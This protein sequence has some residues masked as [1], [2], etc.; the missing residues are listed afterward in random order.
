MGD[1][2]LIINIHKYIENNKTKGY[3]DTWKRIKV[4]RKLPVTFMIKG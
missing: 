1:Y 2:S 3:I 4:D